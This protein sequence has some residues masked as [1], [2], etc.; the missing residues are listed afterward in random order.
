MSKAALLKKKQEEAAL[1]AEEDEDDSAP[2]AKVPGELAVC[3]H[4][5]IP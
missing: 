1:A 5:A 4:L 2:K 3:S